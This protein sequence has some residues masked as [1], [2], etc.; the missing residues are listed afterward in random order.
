MFYIAKEIGKQ[1][2]FFTQL[3]PKNYHLYYSYPTRE[4][5]FLAVKP[6]RCIDC[7]GLILKEHEEDIVCKY[8]LQLAQ[9]LAHPKAII[10]GSKLYIY[11]S[12]DGQASTIEQNNKIFN[13]RVTFISY[14]EGYKDN[15]RFRSQNNNPKR[16]K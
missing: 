6:N 13:T 16:K 14:L 3:I 12:M 11:D 1:A 15:A 10:V 4:D 7:N 5:A 9:W 2:L 8:C